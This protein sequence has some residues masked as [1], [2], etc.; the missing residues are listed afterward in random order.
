MNRGQN[1][2][3]LE[4]PESDMMRLSNDLAQFGFLGNWHSVL[5]FG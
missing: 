2:Q 4:T 1:I 5:T 3:V